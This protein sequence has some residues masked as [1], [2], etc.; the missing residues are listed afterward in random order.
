M[1]R[2]RILSSFGMLAAVTLIFLLNIY[3]S[4]ISAS[5]NDQFLEGSWAVLIDQFEGF[6]NPCQFS[7]SLI[8]SAN[9]GNML[10]QIG[11]VPIPL[12]DGLIM[13]NDKMLGTWERIGEGEFAFRM[14]RVVNNADLV[15]IPNRKFV[16]H[17]TIQLVGD[18]FTA[19]MSGTLMDLEGNVLLALGTLNLSATRIT[20]DPPSIE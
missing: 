10:C 11:Y 6:G 14:E 13:L 16:D 19:T 20:P 8:G 17:G 4:A 5:S 2:K 18:T 3:P 7:S 12:E 1:S 9:T 15:Q